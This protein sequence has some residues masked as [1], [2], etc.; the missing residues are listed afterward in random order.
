VVLVVVSS[1]GFA[2]VAV[3][4]VV[5]GVAAG[6]GPVVDELT[7]GTLLVV[8]VPPDS[9]SAVGLGTGASPSGGSP[10]DGPWAA[11]SPD[12]GEER[13][14]RGTA[15]QMAAVATARSTGPVRMPLGLVAAH[16]D[17]GTGRRKTQ[18]RIWAQS[19]TS[20]KRCQERVTSW[21]SG[22]SVT[23]STVRRG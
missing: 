14:D 22:G 19:G 1:T 6:P 17:S 20:R 3:G 16:S 2:V 4:A 5:A 21:R 13:E 7:D 9:G 23:A 11:T 12:S 8:T 18:T 10:T 15:I